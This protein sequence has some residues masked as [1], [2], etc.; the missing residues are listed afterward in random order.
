MEIPMPRKLSWFAVVILTAALC[1]A[2]CRQEP[3]MP[4]ASAAPPAEPAPAALQA[5]HAPSTPAPE[6]QPL[7]PGHPPISDQVQ[8]A[9]AP[10]A[11]ALAWTVPADWV[12][13]PPSNEMRRAQYRVPGA[14]GD[15]ELVVFYFGPGQGGDAQSNAERWASQFLDDKGQPVIA[16]TRAM[17]AHGIAVTVVE[18]RGNY[19]SGSMT[20]GAVQA[21]PGYALLGAI[22]AGADANWFFKLT[23]PEATVEAQR[24]AFDALMQS[25]RSAG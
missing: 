20:G 12:S 24:A 19:Q 17:D 2:A 4:E 23:G 1:G 18:A 22:A 6:A 16:K 10:A 25:L 3:R 11:G 21:R 14:A 15:A 13:T 5:G 8:P 9:A 7:P